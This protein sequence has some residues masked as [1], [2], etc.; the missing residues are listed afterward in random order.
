MEKGYIH[1]Y[2]GNGKGKT[3]AALGLSLR[4]VCAGKKVFFGQFIKGMKYSELECVNFIPDLVIEQ[5]G[6]DCF[7]Y[8]EPTEED[9]KCARE[10]L[11]KLR[12]ILKQGEY[13]LVV[14]DELNIALLYELFDID[15]VIEIINNRASHVEVIITGRYA[16]DKII[17]IADLVTEMKEVKHYYTQGVEARSGIEK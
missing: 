13:D 11:N 8:N 16:A 15:E 4:A 6:R 12:E 1:V 5:F 14:L 2:T 10:G 17:E 9:I 3:T 7:I